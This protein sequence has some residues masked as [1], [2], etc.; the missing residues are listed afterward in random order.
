MRV[1]AVVGHVAARP[2][3]Q[4]VQFAQEYVVQGLRW[5]RRLR[6]PVAPAH[7]ANGEVRRQERAGPHEHAVGSGHRLVLPVV[8]RIGRNVAFERDANVAGE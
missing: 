6:H 5:R 7:E 3:G 1:V 2:A 8:G 4:A